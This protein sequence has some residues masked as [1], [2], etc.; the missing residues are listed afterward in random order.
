MKTSFAKSSALFVLA[1]TLAACNSGNGGSNNPSNFPNCT[2]PGQ[3]VAVYP[4]SGSTNVPDSTQNVYVASSVALGGQFM[5]VIGLPGG[6]GLVNGNQFSQ[7]PLSQV[8]TPR[9]KPSFSNPIYYI[10]SVGSLT[11]ASTW[12]MY[13]NNTNSANCVPFQYLQFTTQ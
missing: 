1:L 2:A 10:T 12:T 11:A 6:G 13:L 7:V 8:P 5:N 3:F 9:T 4:I